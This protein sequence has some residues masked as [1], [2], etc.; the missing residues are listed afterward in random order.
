MQNFEKKLQKRKVE[1]TNRLK[2]YYVQQ[3]KEGEETGLKP[4][5][6]PGQLGVIPKSMPPVQLTSAQGIN[7]VGLGRNVSADHKNIVVNYQVDINDIDIVEM[8]L[9]CRMEYLFP[10]LKLLLR[11][12]CTGSFRGCL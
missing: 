8:F 2:N 9:I 11:W 12:I 1:D 3:K 4:F 6:S 10:L 7:I 5:M